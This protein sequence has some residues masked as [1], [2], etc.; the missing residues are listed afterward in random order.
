[1]WKIIKTWLPPKSIE[2]IKFVDK[3]SLVEY[4]DREQSM[5]NWGGN[6]NYQ[7]QF[8]PEIVDVVEDSTYLNGDVDEKKVSFHVIYLNRFCLINNSMNLLHVFLFIII[9]G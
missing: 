5:T 8:E 1:M 4:V 9:P 6:D 7:Y 3:K 2:K